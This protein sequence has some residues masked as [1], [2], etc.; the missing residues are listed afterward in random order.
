VVV[1]LPDPTVARLV[2]QRVR[3]LAPKAYI[4]VRAR[5]HVHRWQLDVAGAHA[6]VDE[7]DQVGASIAEE[8]LAHLGS[9]DPD[10][11]LPNKA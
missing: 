4:I 5:Y 10:G 6:V 11:R 3:G 9:L 7:E 2:V 1:T 8:V